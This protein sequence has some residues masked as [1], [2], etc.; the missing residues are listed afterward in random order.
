[1]QKNTQTPPL[2]PQR[3]AATDSPRLAIKSLIQ[4]EMSLLASELA[5]LP[6]PSENHIRR[7]TALKVALPKLT[8]SNFYVKKLIKALFTENVAQAAQ[9]LFLLM[10][11]IRS[12]LDISPEGDYVINSITLNESNTEQAV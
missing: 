2:S 9:N 8:A 10:P 6:R 4:K 5:T 1:M 12:C 7:L 3:N 11:E